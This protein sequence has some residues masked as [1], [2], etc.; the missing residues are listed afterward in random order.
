KKPEA[1]WPKAS[2]FT[3]GDVAEEIAYWT[4]DGGVAK[5]VWRKSLTGIFDAAHDCAMGSYVRDFYVLARV[6][7]PAVL[8]GIHQNFPECGSNGFTISFRD[9]GV[10]RPT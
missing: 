2:S 5:F 10:F 4:A 8:H 7:I 6:E 1:T 3:N 9:F